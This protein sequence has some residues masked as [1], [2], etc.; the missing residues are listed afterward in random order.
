MATNFE[1]DLAAAKDAEQIVK[2]VIAAANYEVFDVSEDP[3]CYHKGDLLVKTLDGERYVEVKDD[4][5]IADTGNILCEE[6]VYYKEN[7][8]T[9]KGNMYS[10]Y[11]IYAVVSKKE[12]KIY[13]FDFKKLK[14][15]YKKYGTPKIIA[16][17]AQESFCFLLEKC[18]ARQFG[19]LIKVVEY[20]EEEKTMIQ[21]KLQKINLLESLAALEMELLM[22]EMEEEINEEE[23]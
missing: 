11:D 8:I 15:I 13:F 17:P 18:R 23:C 22:S 16:H 19:A 6:E 9:V 3:Q 4:S 7:D 2:R 1:R 21:T 20:K 5:R 10:D 14:E 12:R